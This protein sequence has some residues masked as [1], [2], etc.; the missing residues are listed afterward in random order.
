[1]GNREVDKIIIA[2][3]QAN[4]DATEILRYLDNIKSPSELEIENLPSLVRNLEDKSTVTSQ[5]Y[6]NGAAV[7][8]GNVAT[9][10]GISISSSV[11]I[12]GL[13]I[14]TIGVAEA[15]G[16]ALVP[17][18]GWLVV[19]VAAIPFAFKLI[20][21]AKVKKYIKNN[22]VTFKNNQEEIK[23]KRKKL[24]E[25]FT[26]LQEKLV[27]I[28]K[29][30]KNNIDEKYEDYK[31]KVKKLSEDVKI[32][33]DDCINTNTN[34]RILQYNEVILKQYHLQKELENKIEFIFEKY[35]KQLKTK[36]E[37]ERQINCLIKLLNA[38]GCP[39]SVINQ[40]LNESEGN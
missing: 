15:T 1:M 37:L 34:K 31:E 32:Q 30:I 21:E 18:L 5:N 29:E 26:T 13:R 23:K 27:D 10:V 40:A 7:L 2:Y 22:S 25:W 12:R 14:A 33:I 16:V 4:S 3:K 35:N 24:L 38:M 39:E 9:A 11:F 19:P 20:N 6:I 36:F 8:G 17:F 28:D